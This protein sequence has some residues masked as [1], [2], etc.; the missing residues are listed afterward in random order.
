MARPRI[1]KQV[2]AAPQRYV[3]APAASRH[4]L[5]RAADVVARARAEAEAIVARAQER[6]A[7]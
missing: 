3:L 7:A 4:D 6:A 5:Q 1:L 2:E